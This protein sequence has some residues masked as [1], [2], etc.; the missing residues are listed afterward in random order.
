MG[1]RLAVIPTLL[2]I[3]YIYKKDGLEQEP[4]DL[5]V[6][7]FGFGALTV[8]SAVIL[9]V[10]GTII[11]GMVIETEG[12]LFTLIDAFII[13]A[14][15]EELG[16]YVVLKKVTWNHEAFN[17]I[18]DGVVYG[19]F[20]SLGFATIENILYVAEGGV[21]IAILRALTSVPGHAMFGMYMGKHYG[22]A[23]KYANQDNEVEK[24][25]SL[26]KAV[27][28]PILLHGFYDFCVMVGNAWFLLVFL[29]FEIV[30]TVVSFKK[31]KKLSSEDHAI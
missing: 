26:R 27:L 8:I 23:K 22:Q 17:Y 29:I 28:I 20:V 12:M 6:K 10:I 11:V 9:E 1:I 13:T 19:M 24:Q 5:L 3:L 31:L 16:K 15:S 18:F 25:R 4:K 7:L 30:F 21:L 2:L 14:C